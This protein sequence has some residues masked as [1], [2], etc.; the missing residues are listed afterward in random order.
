M[1]LIGCL[2]FFMTFLAGLTVT[3]GSVPI[4]LLNVVV[5]FILALGVVKFIE[6]RF[7]QGGLVFGMGGAFFASL[8]WPYLL[9]LF[10]MD[11]DCRG[12]ECLADIFSIPPP[13]EETAAP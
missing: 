3:G 8:F 2:F 9:L 7:G 5:F 10:R 12:D 1:R 4:A 11:D 13:P 6:P